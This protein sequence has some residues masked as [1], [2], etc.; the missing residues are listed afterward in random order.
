MRFTRIVTT[1]ND[2][3]TFARNPILSKY[4]QYKFDKLPIHKFLA[5]TSPILYINCT[6]IKEESLVPKECLKENDVIF[7]MNYSIETQLMK[8]AKEIGCE[9]VYGIDMLIYNSIFSLQ[10]FLDQELNVEELRD[11]LKNALDNPI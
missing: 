7:D 4:K 3:T 10:L 11:F 1:E 5:K 6:P 2:V 8:D 9:I